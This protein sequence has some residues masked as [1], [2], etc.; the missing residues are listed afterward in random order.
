[1]EACKKFEKQSSSKAK[2]S[3]ASHLNNEGCAS[4]LG[5]QFIWYKSQRIRLCTKLNDRYSE[6]NE[7]DGN[8]QIQN[9]NWQGLT[10]DSLRN[11]VV[12]LLVRLTFVTFAR[13]ATC[14]LVIVGWLVREVRVVAK[15]SLWLLIRKRRKLLR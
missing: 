10:A 3:E 8:T 6:L 1:M 11:W 14:L 12:R 5:L 2:E 7:E 15:R 4:Q 13:I 9:T